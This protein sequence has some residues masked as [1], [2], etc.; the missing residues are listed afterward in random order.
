MQLPVRQCSDRA[1]LG[2]L[3]GIVLACLPALT[4]CSYIKALVI[5][6]APSTEK[7]RAEYDKLE[8]KRVAVYVWVPPEI[9]WDYPRIRLDLAGQLSGYLKEHVKD[10]RMVDPYQVESYLQRSSS[11]EVPAERFREEFRADMVVKVAVFK[12]TMRDPGMSQYYRGRLSASIS[13]ADLTEPSAPVQETPLGEVSVVVPDDQSIGYTNIQPDQLRLQ[14][15]LVFTA[16]AG[17][18]FHD[19]ERPLD[20]E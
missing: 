10:I 5:L 13:V 3:L 11:P 17:K 1:R 20:E 16:E 19:Y 18:K 15:Y 12:F 6:T 8:G 7:V 4:G 14:T 9:A 2:K